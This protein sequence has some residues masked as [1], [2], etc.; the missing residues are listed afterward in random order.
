M[1]EQSKAQS[2]NGKLHGRPFRTASAPSRRR[3]VTSLPNCRGLSPVN[4]AIQTPPGAKPSSRDSGKTL[5]VNTCRRELEP[6]E[7]VRKITF[8]ARPTARAVR[9]ELFTALDLACE[10]PRHPN[11][12]E[13][14]LKTAL[15]ERP[16]YLPG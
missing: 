15:A 1:V 8:R 14:L 12:F 7:D 3:T 10:P 2:S 4:G 13:R 11:E 16:P 6:G 5:A 9:Y